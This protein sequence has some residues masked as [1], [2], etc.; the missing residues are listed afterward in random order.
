METMLNQPTAPVLPGGKVKIWL[1]DGTYEEVPTIAPAGMQG[2][3]LMLSLPRDAF[4][5]VNMANI[6]RWEWHPSRIAVVRGAN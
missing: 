3:F 5:A 2:P 4:I 1:D 6:R